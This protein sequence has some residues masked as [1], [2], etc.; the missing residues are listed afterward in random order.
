[1]RITAIYASCASKDF[2]NNQN[3][4]FS[5]IINAKANLGN[6]KKVIF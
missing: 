2:R 1:M 4:A 5:Y 6:R 3:A